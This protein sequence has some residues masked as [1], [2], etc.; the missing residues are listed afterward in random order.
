VEA[1]YFRPQVVNQKSYE[2]SAQNIIDTLSKI[3]C[4]EQQLNNLKI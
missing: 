3:K 1:N 4:E 2:K